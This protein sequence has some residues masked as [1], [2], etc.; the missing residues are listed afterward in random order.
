MSHCRRMS[1]ETLNPAK[2]FRECK[3]FEAPKE[4]LDR[5]HS[6]FQLETDH[7]PESALL[8]CGYLVSRMP[9]EPVIVNLRDG[10]RFMQSVRNRCRVFFM[11]PYARVESADSAQR[12][13]TVE[14]RA[15]DSEAVRPPRELF[16]ECCIFRYNCSTDDVAVPVQVFRRRMHHEISAQLDWLLKRRREKGVVDH[17][18]RSRLMTS[19]RKRIDI[20]DPKQRIARRL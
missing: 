14:W 16:T 8:R 9:W 1:D 4:S 15:R 5:T 6:A 18:N 11:N 3:A 17:N 7:A 20:G 2:R 19:R 10:G 13:K 12:Q